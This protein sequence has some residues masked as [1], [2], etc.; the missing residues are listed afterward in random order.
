MEPCLHNVVYL[1]D[2]ESVADNL[3]VLAQIQTIDAEFGTGLQYQFFALSTED[4]PDRT[5][6]PLAQAESHLAGWLRLQR[7][8]DAVSETCWHSVELAT[9][10]HDQPLRRSTAETG[11]VAMPAA[12]D[13]ACLCPWPR[14]VAADDPRPCGDRAALEEVHGCST[15]ERW[16]GGKGE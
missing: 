1:L 12:G 5:I 9:R 7:R 15:A 10:I 8:V 4:K 16:R 11:H 2:M 3:R 14:R 13:G 6:I